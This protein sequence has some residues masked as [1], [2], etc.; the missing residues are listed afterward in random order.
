MDHTDKQAGIRSGTFFVLASMVSA[1][2][3]Y[4][5]YIICA[6]MLSPAQ[7]GDLALVLALSNQVLGALFATNLLSIYIMHNKGELYARSVLELVQRRILI[8]IFIL[9]TSTVVLG[10]FFAYLLGLEDRWLIAC[11]CLVLIMALPASIWIGF[12]QAQKEFGRISVY[13][14]VA[15]TGKLVLTSIGA[16]LNSVRLALLG[17]VIGQGLALFIIK[18]YRGSTPPSVIKSLSE[19]PTKSVLNYFREHKKL[20]WVAICSV[21]T[22]SFAQNADIVFANIKLSDSVVGSYSGISLISNAIFYVGSL[23][24]WLFLPRIIKLSNNK[25]KRIFRYILVVTALL[26]V[27]AVI[28]ARFA[29]PLLVKIFL[30]VYIAPVARALPYAVAYQ[31]ILISTA[32][33]VYIFILQNRIVN[34]VIVIASFLVYS[35]LLM[36]TFGN[37]VV[38]IPLSLAGALIG[39]WLTYGIIEIIRRKYRFENFK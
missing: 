20:F 11:L 10:S 19:R 14:L 23:L 15:S 4:I 3:N 5:L 7:Y 39:S 16:T 25:Q 32:L 30:G 13:N 26:V 2:C 29:G 31:L 17:V 18:V 1:A 9:S 27:V 21:L 8:I 36:Y 28:F 34:A 37:D 33:S 24:F 38:T 6:R 22:L 12:F 35:T